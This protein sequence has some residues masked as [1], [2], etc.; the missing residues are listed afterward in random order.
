VAK[1]L[2]PDHERVSESNGSSG[3]ARRPPGF[4]QRA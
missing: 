1:R 2:G 3:A 4:P